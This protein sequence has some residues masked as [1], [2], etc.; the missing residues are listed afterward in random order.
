MLQSK[1]YITTISHMLKNLI[2]DYIFNSVVVVKS[3][4]KIVKH[5]FVILTS[6]I[7]YLELNNNKVNN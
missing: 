3:G 6:T 4:I 2:K 5:S 7:L 1:I